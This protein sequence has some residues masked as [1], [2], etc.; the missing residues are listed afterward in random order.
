MTLFNGTK[1][2]KG[3]SIRSK[4]SRQIKYFLL[5]GVF[6]TFILII[7]ISTVGRQEFGSLQKAALELVGPAQVAVSRTGN[8][9]RNVWQDYKALWNVR[10][11]NKRLQEEL[12]RYKA[13]TSDY[14]EAVATNLR[15]R[16]LLEFKESLPPPTLTAEIIGKDPSLWF[17]TV[18]VNRGS[19]DGVRKGM[20]AVTVEGIVGQVLDTS[21]HYAKILLATD[22]N[23]AIDVLIQKTRVH[24]ILNGNGNNAY[25]L[26]YVLK[27]SDIKKGD[28]VVTSELGG[29]F[30]KGLPVGAVSSVIRS[31]RGMFQRIEVEPVVDFSMLE[32]LI[33]IMKKN[34]LAE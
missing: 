26:Q 8:Y 31:R 4:R 21:P 16:K 5:F 3:G 15:L 12:R 24:G 30:P 17:R 14:R 19:S 18:T 29:V 6:L 10:E 1:R 27:K 28:M 32:N 34:H 7:I 13:L 33:I 22:P 11:D 2:K 9:C 25:Q 23:S 20:P